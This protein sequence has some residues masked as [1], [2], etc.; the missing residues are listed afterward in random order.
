[1]LCLTGE[2][3]FA[4]HMERSLYNALPGAVNSDCVTV[5]GGLPFDSYSPLLPGLRGRQMGGYKTMDNG[6]YY[7]CC[8]C[9]GAAGLGLTGM[10]AAVRE[11]GGIVLNPYLPGAIRTGTPGGAALTLDVDTT[12]PVG[13][14]VRIAV[15]PEKAE[16]FA[17]KLRV[18]DWSE[19]TTPGHY[20][21]VERL[22]QDGDT[23]ELTLD[24]RVMPVRPEDYGVSSGEAPYMALRRG[25]LVLARDARLGQSVDA[26]VELVQNDD[27]SVAAALSEYSPLC[28]V[29]AMDVQLADGTTMPVIDYVSA[30]KT[31]QEDSRMCAWIPMKR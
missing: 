3:E 30:G 28:C 23:V 31:G 16:R 20:A 11:A 1:M 2:A 10:S 15:H 5:N 27:G 18:P 12:Y 14:D 21:E 17:L 9:I 22:W 29:V 24:M 19:K 25:P 26:P 4:A 13:G 7:G 8:A 6:T